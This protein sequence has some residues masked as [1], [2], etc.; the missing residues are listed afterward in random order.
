MKFTRREFLKTAF[1]SAASLGLGRSTLPGRSQIKSDS[2]NVILLVF[3]S[4][5]ARHLSLLGYPRL[6]TPHLQKFAETATVYH[7]HYAAGNFTTPST[8][9]LLTGA[10]PWTHRAIQQSGLIDRDRTNQNLFASLNSS[11][12]RVAFAQNV[13]ADLFLYQFKN[14]IDIH[15]KSTAFSL[16]NGMRYNNALGESDSLASFRAFDDFLEQD[17]GLP[18][19][20]YFSLYDKLKSYL[21]QKMRPT[22]LA[23]EYP[24]GIPTFMKYKLYFLLNDVFNGVKNEIMG[25]Q[26]PFVG[27]FHFW[28]PH[29]PYT[30]NRQFVGLFN[31]DWIPAPKP[32]H[33][34]GGHIPEEQL[35]ALRRQ[36]DEYVANLDAEFGNFYESLMDAGILENSYVIVTADHG[37]YFERGVHGHGTPLLYDPVINVPL[38]ISAPGQTV[39]RDV[40]SATSCV[41]V[42][43][44]IL[45]ITASDQPAYS[46]GT[47]LPGFIENEAERPVFAMEAKLNS[48]FGP[49]K[50]GTFAM[51]QGDYKLIWYRGY[52]GSDDTYELYNIKS[53]PEELDDLSASDPHVLQQMAEQLKQKLVGTEHY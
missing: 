53:D 18:G 48:A 5:S 14:S 12:Q 16:E 1:V 27:Y 28:T 21:A 29:E 3:D 50:I 7:H 40:Y 11:Y 39:R 34:F 19:S 47:L 32:M 24:R 42:L 46:E 9:S 15:L 45:K 20:L 35:H 49:L 2:P 31:D 43:P 6:T 4:L 13:W 30:P 38:I 10:Y 37:Q 22:T 36:Y 25:L 41:D 26:Q 8:A 33:P 52:A 44:T 51:I 17:Y 23:E